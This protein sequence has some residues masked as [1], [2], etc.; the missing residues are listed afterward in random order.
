[1]L[2]LSEPPE[3]LTGAAKRA[4]DHGSDARSEDSLTNSDR[5]GDA[6]KIALLMVSQPTRDKRSIDAHPFLVFI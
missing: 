2:Y 3:A 4:V 5:V 6:H 1:M